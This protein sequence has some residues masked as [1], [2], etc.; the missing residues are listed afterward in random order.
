M[1]TQ[2]LTLA[3][4]LVQSPATSS[5][6][7]GPSLAPAQSAAVT[8]AAPVRPRGF[9]M[10]TTLGV[11]Y[12]PIFP[13]PSGELSLFFGGV[14]PLASRRPG[15]WTALGYR[16]TFSLGMADIFVGNGLLVHRHHLAVQ[17]AAG[18]RGRFYYGA[19]AGLALFIGMPS[20]STAARRLPFDLGLEGE[21][22]IGGIF[23]DGRTQLI[24]GMQLRVSGRIN[25]DPGYNP[26]RAFPTLGFFIGFNFGPHLGRR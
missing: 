14:L 9:V 24:V 19:S 6:V 21:G 20:E 26:P 11:N 10:S 5:V 8:D 2:G 13:I 23:G 3:L 25:R 17:G 18:R 12:L 4:A 22:R 15:H 16:G 7:E 1:L